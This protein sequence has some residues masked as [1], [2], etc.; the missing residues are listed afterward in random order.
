MTVISTVDI[1]FDM[2]LCSLVNPNRI[3]SLVV[4]VHSYDAVIISNAYAMN[5]TYHTWTNCSQH[6]NR[7][8]FCHRRGTVHFCLKTNYELH[9]LHTKLLKLVDWWMMR[10]WFLKATLMQSGISSKH[11]CRSDSIKGK[12][13][14]CWN[15][16]HLYGDKCVLQIHNTDTILK[17][18]SGHTVE[19]VENWCAYYENGRKTY[20]TLRK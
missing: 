17:V 7:H 3:C 9:I 5:D 14:I 8:W 20:K 13:W 15:L 12:P 19:W 10:R 1:R 11:L 6:R 4:D 16:F 2:L 18:W